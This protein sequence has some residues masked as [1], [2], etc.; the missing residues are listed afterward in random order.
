MEKFFLIL[1]VFYLKVL[2]TLISSLQFP[3]ISK[4]EYE[5][6]P[7]NILNIYQILSPPAPFDCP[8]KIFF[9]NRP[10]VH[11]NVLTSYRCLPETV[12]QAGR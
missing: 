2:K 1:K 6:G 8:Q 7:E 10:K 5:V 4:R 12:C 11:N 9:F 3:K